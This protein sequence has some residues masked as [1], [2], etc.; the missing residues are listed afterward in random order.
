MP[1]YRN[2]K[3]NND[4]YM[5]Y[6]QIIKVIDEIAPVFKLEDLTTCITSGCSKVETIKF[7]ATDNCANASE[8]KFRATI[9][10]GW[11]C[12]DKIEYQIHHR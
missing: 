4:G 1:V 12:R 3:D 8:I 10:A 9:T 2:I 6:V 11:H 7:S 5:Q